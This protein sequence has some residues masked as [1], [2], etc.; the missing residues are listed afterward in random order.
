MDGGEDDNVDKD[1]CAGGGQKKIGARCKCS[2]TKSES[3]ED[4]KAY[5]KSSSEN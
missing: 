2:A 1:G 3:T 4:R 5:H